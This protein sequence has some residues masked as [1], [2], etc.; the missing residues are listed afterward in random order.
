LLVVRDYLQRRRRRTTEEV[1]YNL[2]LLSQTD[3]VDVASVA[4]A[5]G[6]ASAERLYTTVAPRGHRLLAKVPRLPGLVADR[7]VEHFGSLQ[8][9]LSATGEDLAMGARGGGRPARGARGRT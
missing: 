2:A 6:L 3:L 4:A 9:L 5:M 1:L 8:K 7:L